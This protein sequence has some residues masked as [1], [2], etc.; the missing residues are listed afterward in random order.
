MNPCL[1]VAVAG[2]L[3]T[4]AAGCSYTTLFVIVNHS[5]EPIRIAYSVRRLDLPPAVKALRD[6]KADDPPWRELSVPRLSE[7]KNIALTLVLG[8]D[9]VLRVASSAAGGLFN[10]VS[11][12]IRTPGGQRVFRGEEAQRAFRESSRTLFVLEYP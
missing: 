9:S 1:R 7:A 6:L 4:A 12:E 3:L 10:V 5:K 8:P 2:T 11:V